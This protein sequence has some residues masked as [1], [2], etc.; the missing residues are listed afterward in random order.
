MRNCKAKKSL[1]AVLAMLTATLLAEWPF[2][3]H[4]RR[5]DRNDAREER[6]ADDKR[7]D[8]GFLNKW[9]RLTT[10]KEKP[11][12][13]DER[14]QEPQPEEKPPTMDEW[15][16]KPQTKGKPPTADV[17][18]Q[19]ASTEDFDRIEIQIGMFPPEKSD[20]NTV[21]AVIG[22]VTYTYETL[23]KYLK[24]RAKLSTETPVLLMC[25]LESPHGNLIKV[26][27][28]CYKYKMRKIAILSQ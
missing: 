21:G 2:D 19:F 24:E 28:I 13:A 15:S 17:R 9:K 1:L 23:D 26:L 25:P 27:D 4:D 8:K 14:P 3:N 7:E 10:K 18:P 22:G 5:A 20:K 11:S 16:Q 6:K 12:A